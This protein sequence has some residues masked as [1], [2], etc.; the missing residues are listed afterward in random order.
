MY[1]PIKDGVERTAESVRYTVAKPPEHLT[2]LVHCYWEIKTEN[3]L[4][5]DFHL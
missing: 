1:N 2:G 3:A 5:E 4:A